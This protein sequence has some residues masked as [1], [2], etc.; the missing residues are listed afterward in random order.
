[1]NLPKQ[2]LSVALIAG[3]LASACTAGGNKP[4]P[5]TQTPP[6]AEAPKPAAPARTVDWWMQQLSL[7]EKV[8]QLFWFGLPEAATTPEAEQLVKDGKVGGFIFFA[9]QG[10]DPEQLRKMTGRLQALAAE[11]QRP[12]PGLVI[13][14]DHEGGIVQRWGPPYFTTWPGNMAIGATRSEAYAE[15][16]AAAMAQELSSVGVTM[17]LAPDVDVNNNPANPVIGVRS[18][19]EDPEL[20]AKLATAAIRGTQNQNVS[21]VAKHFPG[22]G[23]T[24]VDSHMAMPSVPHAMDR[25]EKVELAP[26]KAAMAA[27]V[28]VVMSAHIMFPAVATDNHPATLS[29]KVM[30]ELLKDKLGFK[31]VAVTDAI[32]SM[33]AITDNYG[34]ERALVMAIQAGVDVLLVTDSFAKQASFHAQ[35]V[36]AVKDGR[37]S[38]ARL[39]DAVRRNLELKAKR[40]LLPET[41]TKPAAPAAVNS[42]ANR[43]LSLQVGADALTL[44]RNRHL[45]LKLTAEQTVLAVGPSY[46]AQVTGT[47]DVLTSLGAG[48]KAVHPK[49]KE[50]VLEKKPTAEKVAAVRSAAQTADVI[51]YGVANAR[52][53]A[54]HQAL[55]KELIASGKPVIV[56]GMGEPYDLT[57]LPG[58]ETYVAAYGYQDSNLRGVGALLFGQAQ[59]KG[60]LPV[61]IPDLY[62]LGHGLAY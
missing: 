61:S 46:A 56:V 13:S 4:Q 57:A 52:N 10:N 26:F 20:V 2:L 43:K 23:D 39:N 42:D 27:G 5:P 35:I 51:V 1:M 50:V 18:Y 22:H 32:D 49:V 54:D 7:E 17:N 62:P 9:R 59:P 30:Q 6:A 24:A 44:V 31:G 41:G 38:E 12:T 3:L 28:D 60:K 8:G 19:G 55:I 25:L 16:V 36:Q 11:R 58:I 14:V 53:Y 33:R 34:L 15:Q 40:G 21:A 45:P 47:P 29:P 37:I 48:L